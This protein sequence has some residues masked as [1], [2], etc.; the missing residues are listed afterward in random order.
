MEDENKEIESSKVGKY[1]LYAIVAILAISSIL[2]RIFKEGQFYQTAITYV[3]L[4]AFITIL[5]IKFSGTPKSSYGIVFKV[6]TI[7]LLMAATLLGEGTV[8]VLMAAPIFYGIAAI[9]VAIDNYFKKDNKAN[10]TYS[11]VSI[12]AIV[13]LFEPQSFKQNSKLREITSTF[14]YAKNL[15]FE[16][17]NKTRN[18]Q[19][20]LPLFFKTGFP[21]PIKVEGSGIDVGNTRKIQFESSEKTKGFLTLIISEK[22]Q[23]QITFK[24]VEDNT[25]MNEWL[26]WDSIKVKIYKNNKGK[27]LVQWTSTY[28][29]DLGPHWY[30]ETLEDFAVKLMNQH[31]INSYFD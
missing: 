10:K 21:K 30:F 22:T 19:K 1:Q 16:A 29:C 20:N 18:L 25:K 23:N 12:L 26:T 7:F 8:C 28:S 4:P 13:L 31:L 17:F 9:I 11:I 6:I 2:F 14:I 27:S 24:V 3:L 5:V 15:D